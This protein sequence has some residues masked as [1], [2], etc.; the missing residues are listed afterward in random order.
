MLTRFK[1]LRNKSIDEDLS[2]GI[3]VTTHARDRGR[4]SQLSAV[5]VLGRRLLDRRSR[6]GFGLDEIGDRDLT[7]W[8][9]PDEWRQQIGEGPEEG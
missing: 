8:F 4:A 6:R 5:V 2:F 9:N 7:G 3:H 1:Q